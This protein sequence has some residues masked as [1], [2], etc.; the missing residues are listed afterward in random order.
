MIYHICFVDFIQ[1]FWI[2]RALTGA[3]LRVIY[4]GR[5]NKVN[6]FRSKYTKIFF[7]PKNEIFDQILVYLVKKC[8]YVPNLHKYLDRT[9]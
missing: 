3:W 2:M 6:A 1:T 8:K 5:S 9:I 4:D 7:Y